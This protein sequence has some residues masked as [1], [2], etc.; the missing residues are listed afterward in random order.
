MRN[1][2]G[3]SCGKLPSAERISC[4][5]RRPACRGIPGRI[6]LPL[7]N[8]CNLLRK[9]TSSLRQ[10]TKELIWLVLGSA[11]FLDEQTKPTNCLYLVAPDGLVVDRYDKCL[12]TGGDQQHY[13]AGSAHL[14]VTNVPA[15]NELLHY[16]YREGWTL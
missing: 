16:K 8:D 14:K 3:I 13:S 12:C 9:E 1:T 2:F 7:R 10:L 6:F 5:P 11:H 4:T 15:A